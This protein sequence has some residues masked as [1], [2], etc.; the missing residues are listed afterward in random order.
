MSAI[1]FPN[2]HTGYPFVLHLGDN[3]ACP[4]C[5]CGTGHTAC[6]CPS[7]YYPRPACELRPAPIV[8]LTDS[9]LAIE[10]ARDSDDALRLSRAVRCCKTLDEAA[11]LLVRDHL[12]EV[13]QREIECVTCHQTIAT[14]E[15]VASPFHCNACLGKDD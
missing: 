13:E 9:K 12:C 11:A 5:P 1:Y 14:A 7:P 6:A 8:E 10:F 2:P 15:A 4:S 3:C